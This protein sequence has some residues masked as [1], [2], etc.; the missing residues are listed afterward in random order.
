MSFAGYQSGYGAIRGPGVERA[1]PYTIPQVYAGYS[2]DPTS[3][4]VPQTQFA[5]PPTEETPTKQELATCTVHN[6]ARLTTVLVPDEY[7]NYVCSP[8]SQCKMPQGDG[9]ARV[10][11]ALCSVHEK[12]RS[13]TFL[14]EEEEGSGAYRCLP[15]NECK[16]KA[17]PTQQSQP[18]PF[19][20][21]PRTILIRRDVGYGP[22]R[23]PNVPAMAPSAGGVYCSLHRKSRSMTQLIDDG[24]GGWQ[25]RP[26]SECKV[27]AASEQEQQAATSES[28]G[29]AV[30]SIHY[31]NR[32]MQ[33]LQSDG[34]GGFYCKA[35][36]Q[37]KGGGNPPP[38][39]AEGGKNDWP[40]AVPTGVAVCTV[41]NKNRS[42]SCLQDDGADGYKCSDAQTCKV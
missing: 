25:C 3:L 9:S 5:F 10:G 2:F 13:L 8:K 41:H 34:M 23:R 21:N 40:D 19:A 12:M 16:S 26:G 30:C 28:S 33:V 4:M 11:Q 38:A 1:S 18:I 15:E 32:S 36:T 20:Y 7:G 37:C 35:D 31:K 42:M 17:T 22:Y 29:Y 39:N 27:K 6:K 24:R 14:E